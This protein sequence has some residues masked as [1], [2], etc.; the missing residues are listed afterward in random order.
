MSITSCSREGSGV[1]KGERGGGGLGKGRGQSGRVVSSCGSE[2]RGPKGGIKRCTILSSDSGRK[3]GRE[4]GRGGRSGALE[5]RSCGMTRIGNGS[6]F[7]F[8]ASI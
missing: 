6:S 4:G 3:G 2:L 7:S 5:S 1:G 8:F